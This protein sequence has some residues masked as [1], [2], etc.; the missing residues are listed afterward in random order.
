MDAVLKYVSSLARNHCEEIGF[1]P[2]PTLEHYARQGQLWVETENDDLCGFLVFGNG[3]R[4]LKIYQACIQYD[5]RRREHGLRLMQRLIIHAQVM[6]FD[7]ISCWCADDLD[8]NE[9]WRACGFRWTR[10]REG[11]RARGRKHNL[12]V[13]WLPEPLQSRLFERC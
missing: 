11:G 8:A 4:T 9:F 13:L 3:R 2:L 5:A 10:Q 12:W 7:A 1:I 6:G